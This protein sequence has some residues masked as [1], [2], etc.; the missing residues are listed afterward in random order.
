MFLLSIDVIETYNKALNIKE[1]NGEK[2]DKS[3][4]FIVVLLSIIGLLGIAI[5]L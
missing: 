2:S 5:N 4:I 1:A 3:I